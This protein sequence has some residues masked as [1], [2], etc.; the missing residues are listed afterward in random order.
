MM[1]VDTVRL[2]TLEYAWIVDRLGYAKVIENKVRMYDVPYTNPY[3][4]SQA[5]PI[6]PKGPPTLTLPGLQPDNL[7][8]FSEADEEHK[9]GLTEGLTARQMEK[10]ETENRK[11]L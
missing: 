2:N 8:T 3:R 11:I 9:W 6:T 5:D 7:T 1:I 10:K 4:A